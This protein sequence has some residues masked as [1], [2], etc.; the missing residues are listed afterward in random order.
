M[1][2]LA[3]LIH[4]L[5]Y[6][7]LYSGHQDSDIFEQIKLFTYSYSC[8]NFTLFILCVVLLYAVYILGPF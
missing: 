3:Q 6:S 7:V 8:D 1:Q 2:N 5:Y 4:H